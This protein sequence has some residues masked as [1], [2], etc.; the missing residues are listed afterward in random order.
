MTFGSYTLGSDAWLEI[1]L[2]QK[3]L[4]EQP[5]GTDVDHEK[6]AGNFFRF[7]PEWWNRAAGVGCTIKVTSGTARLL[8][9]RVWHT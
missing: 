3:T 7:K 6:S 5:A 1:D 9:R 4:T 8:T 2:R